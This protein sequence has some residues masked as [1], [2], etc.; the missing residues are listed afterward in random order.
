[1]N[2]SNRIE[3]NRIDLVEWKLNGMNMSCMYLYIFFSLSLLF[4][5]LN[6]LRGIVMY[7]R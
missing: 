1:M 5:I 4:F 2:E 6:G 3:S 7:D